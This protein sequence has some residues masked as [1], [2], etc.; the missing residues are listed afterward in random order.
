MKARKPL[1]GRPK[2]AQQLPFCMHCR[3]LQLL[4]I[5]LLIR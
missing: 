4:L 2:H 3:E 1:C 5:E